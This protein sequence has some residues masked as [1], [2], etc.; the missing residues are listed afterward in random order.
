MMRPIPLL[1]LLASCGPLVTIGASGP[2]TE[3][4]LT[5]SAEPPAVP[6]T[7][8]T[9]LDMESAIAVDTP[10]VPGVLQTRRI[11]VH[12]ADTEIRYVPVAQWSEQPNRL[13]RQLLSDRLAADGL[14]VVD[15]RSSGR[16]PGR[17]LTGQLLLFGVDVRSGQQARVRYDATLADRNGVHQRRF[18][19]EEPVGDATEGGAVAAALN[20]AT[21]RLAGEV[22]D[23]VRTPAESVSET[24]PGSVLDRGSDGR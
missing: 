23:W 20:R 6:G 24:V 9:A 19:A 15:P 18:E 14:A 22:S 3:S 1:L 12:V 4:L 10:V 7:P 2:R 8:D 5:L 17:R 13:F 16:V 21:N 11:P